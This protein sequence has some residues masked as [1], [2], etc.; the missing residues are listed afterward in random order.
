MCRSWNGINMVF[1]SVIVH[2]LD[3][4]LG[5][6]IQNL[7]AEKLKIDLWHGKIYSYIWV[8]C[9][10]IVPFEEQNR[11][12]IKVNMK[13]IW[14][15]HSIIPFVVYKP[16]LFP[17]M[18]VFFEIC[19]QNQISIFLSYINWNIFWSHFNITHFIRK[20]TKKKK[21]FRLVGGQ[22]L[23]VFFLWII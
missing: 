23:V 8:N 22:I 3:K 13:K 6:Y 10:G 15:A 7:D 11:K 1:E 18:N 2:L 14:V 16:S 20:Q 9:A 19:C 21:T 17:T 5:D 4:Y 12:K